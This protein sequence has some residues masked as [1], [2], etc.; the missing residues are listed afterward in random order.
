MQKDAT[1]CAE[2]WRVLR[3]RQTKIKDH[4]SLELVVG[5]VYNDVRI[6]EAAIPTT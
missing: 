1:G 4:G 5:D 3:Q 6:V 2:A